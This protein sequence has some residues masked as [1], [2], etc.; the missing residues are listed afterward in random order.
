MVNIG[1]LCFYQPGFLHVKAQW[2]WGC[3]FYGYCEN[4]VWFSAKISRESMT[5]SGGKYVR[6]YPH[7]EQKMER[8][9]GGGGCCTYPS[10]ALFT[11][12]VL[13]V[14]RVDR[15]ATRYAGCSFAVVATIECLY[16]LST[17]SVL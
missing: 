11:D 8:E 1:E 7:D 16:L 12:H 13:P 3:I 10:D 14:G 6:T 2:D 4:F 9:G 5:F 17:R 15:S